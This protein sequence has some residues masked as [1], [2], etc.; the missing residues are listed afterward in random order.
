MC[1]CIRKVLLID[2]GARHGVEE[3]RIFGIEGET[4]LQS[5]GGDAEAVHVPRLDT[6][7]EQD[8]GVVGENGTGV[9]E[10]EQGCIVAACV[11]GVQGEGDGGI[12]F[13]RAGVR[14][15]WVGAERGFKAVHGLR[16][17]LAL[18]EEVA[19]SVV[20][21]NRG[22]VEGEC[23]L[24]E[25]F[26]L[27]GVALVEAIDCGG[28]EGSDLEGGGLAGLRSVRR[29]TQRARRQHRGH[30]EEQERG[31]R[32]VCAGC[33]AGDGES[34]WQGKA[35]EHER[36]DQQMWKAKENWQGRL[37]KRP[38]RSVCMQLLELDATG[39]LHLTGSVDGASRYTE[40]GIVG[41]CVGRAERVAVEGIQKF[42]FEGK[43]R[44]LG[45]GCFL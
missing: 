43:Y 6:D 4:R 39:N 31:V 7:V 28:D 12:A 9:L 3:L 24:E 45:E 26:G 29:G 5:F 23:V 20:G 19:V 1:F 27:H 14:I 17:M 21:G 10:A 13:R 41:L 8:F 22:R 34:R 44:S 18:D 33:V 42:D 35:M 36:D 11:A 16:Q 40:V 15:V 37:E 38:C 25:V 2:L 30:K 32:P